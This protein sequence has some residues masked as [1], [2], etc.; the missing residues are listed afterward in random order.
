[1]LTVIV[2]VVAGPEMPGPDQ[3]TAFEAVAGATD[4]AA[5]PEIQVGAVIVGVRVDPTPVMVTDFTTICAG[6]PLD[7]T[8]KV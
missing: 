8:E 6:Q 1:M 2:G 5:V 7:V 3:K 4:I